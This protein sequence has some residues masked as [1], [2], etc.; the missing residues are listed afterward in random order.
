MRRNV[1]FKKQRETA[2]SSEILALRTE[3]A[4]AQASQVCLIIHVPYY[5]KKEGAILQ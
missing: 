5:L 2:V 3:N 4:V 1:L